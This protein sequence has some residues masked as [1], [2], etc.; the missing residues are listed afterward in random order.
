[1]PT[2]TK[3]ILH[4]A[5][6]A[7]AALVIAISGSALYLRLAIMP[8]VEQYKGD[9]E[10][11]AGRAIGVPVRIGAIEADWWGLNPRFSLRDLSLADTHRSPVSLKRVDA[12]LSWLSLFVW[13]LRLANIALYE[14]EL[15]VR[16]DRDGVV[17]VAEIPVN[18]PGPRS[19]FPDWLLRQRLI[20]VS[21][22]VLTWSDEQTGAPPLVLS[23][24]NLILRNR[25]DRH[26]LGLTAK[27]P[28]D[29]LRDLDIR[30]D[31]HGG[32]IH[33]WPDWTGRAYLRADA[34][35]VQALRRWAPWAQEQV[36]DGHGDVRFWLDL[37]A[38]QVTGLT[39]DVRLSDVVVSLAQ[40]HPDM[41]FHDLAGR[42]GWSRNR[43]LHT[44][45]A[46][47]LS[48]TTDD[49][50]RIGPTNV[51]VQTRVGADGKIILTGARA[52]KLRVEA[53]TALSGA[54]PMPK[55]M[56]DWIQARRPR[57]YIETADLEWESFDKYK[58][59][60][61]FLDA[62]IAPTAD[63][64]GIT[65]VDGRVTATG[66]GGEAQFNARHL[67]FQYDRVFRFPID[68]ENFA[69]GLVWERLPDEGLRLKIG[70]THLSNADLE[71]TAEGSIEIRRGQS[72]DLD[73]RAHL[74]RGAGNAVWRYL[75]KAVSD[76]AFHWIKDSI[77]A[78]VSPDT[79]L[80][81]KGPADHFPWDK[82]GGEFQVAIQ[83]KDARLRY[84]PGWPEIN[85]INGQVIFKGNGMHIETSSARILGVALGPATAVIPDLHSSD[86]EVL[87]VEGQAKG[88]TPSFL[89]F[90][91]KSP[92]YEHTGRFTDR[93]KAEGQGELRL[94]LQLPLRAIAD[95]TVHGDY[96]LTDNSIHPGKDLPTLTQVNG[97]LSFT[98][99]LVRADN[100]NARIHGQPVNLRITSET[101]GRIKVGLS[102]QANAA[103]LKEWL[104]TGGERYLTGATGYEAEV[105]LKAQQTTLRVK[106]D[107]TGLAINLPAPIAKSADQAIPLTLTTTDGG[108]DG[109]GYTVQYG[110]ILSAKVQTS[111]E[112]R[113][114]LNFG[115]AMPTTLPR[116]PGIQIQGTLKRLDLDAWR[117]LD[118]QPQASGDGKAMPSVRGV[119]VTI[120]ELRALNRLFHD[121]R[122]KATP[123]PKGWRLEINGKEVMGEVL[124]AEAGGL[125]GKRFT[126][127]FQ[128]LVIP[129]EIPGA[130]QTAND[131]TPTE[132]PRILEINTQSFSIKDREI[133]QLNTHMEAERSGL[134]TRSLTISNPD[135]Q[136]KGEGWVSASHR[137]PTQFDIQ[138][139]TENAG[140]LLNRLGIT[141]GIRGGAATLSGTVS[142]LGRPEDFAME[143]LDG[144]LKL[145]MKS[146]RFTQLDP[147]A[148]RLIGILSLQALPRRIV[149]DF[150]DVFSEGFSFDS[151]EGDVHLARG[152]AYLPD[153]VI[154]GPAAVV[155]MKGK[156]DL[157]KEEQDL[158]VTIQ[159]RLDD[160]LAVAGALL[161]GPVVGVGTLV[162]T[163]IL[164]N[165]VS[166]AAT[167]EYLIKGTWLEPL[168]NKLARP[169]STPQESPLN[170]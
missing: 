68:L 151:I 167:Y 18:T 89:E 162:A 149:L 2:L 116:D 79:R 58:L 48:F 88:M 103:T 163:K 96:R 156:I 135:G 35:S 24:L 19:P 69:T 159:P 94:K 139:D 54:I 50:Q 153:L 56:H 11:I 16:R 31:L 133:G 137:L 91:R 82:G 8:N 169:Q 140:K 121:T 100:L 128:K 15:T 51:R 7:A 117:E 97:V 112:A 65:G 21:N 49:G 74:T 168:I 165:P 105:S 32:S 170:P 115:G 23:K 10:M 118:Q 86:K 77:V 164:Q 63:L 1:M 81:L 141:E 47:G 99:N 27:P 73:I 107:L 80:T 66:S 147:G 13:D 120:G 134:R 124:Y 30:A 36:L 148:G 33:Q 127:H 4:Y 125:P 5:V 130:T 110:Q 92:V 22:G 6:Y 109:N 26:Q 64:P 60:A 38:G 12:T 98:E 93:I 83:A 57:G 157:A 37:K 71:A 20:V 102:G 42:L 75:P 143:N 3:R 17:Y 101:G 9:I 142:W 52:E 40:D 72:P 138:L 152:V 76:D 87:I 45:L 123:I 39:G 95:S 160:S 166:K 119:N 104:P 29:S 61:R 129:A 14:P 136:L 25:A 155:H 41:V 154:R 146:G 85:G 70:A 111:D 114:A 28:V 106:S 78:G 126:G 150:R 53:L 44:L 108:A 55:P 161:G 131:D 34:A 122:V 158:R 144:K 62:G 90:I 113:V 67:A 46:Q 84:A 132:L 43:D 145:R 59:S